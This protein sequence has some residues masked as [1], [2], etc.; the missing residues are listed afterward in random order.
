MEGQTGNTSS[1]SVGGSSAVSI[2]DEAPAPVSHA[3]V[4]SGPGGPIDHAAAS[5]AFGHHADGVEP[6]AEAQREAALMGL[7]EEMREQM[8]GKSLEQIRAHLNE[9]AYKQ[10]V[11]DEMY[12]KTKNM[13]EEQR[14]DYLNKVGKAQKVESEQAMK[15]MSPAQ[16]AKHKAATMRANMKPADV[17]AVDK[18]I[19]P[20]AAG[21][22]HLANELKKP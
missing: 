10:Q 1:S 11:G 4:P 16:A 7:P 8:K 17:A 12:A 14:R 22:K 18:A 15:H 21:A 19:A 9:E 5:Q 20:V 13:G 6:S 2:H 3:P